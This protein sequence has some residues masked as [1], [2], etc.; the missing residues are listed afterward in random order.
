MLLTHC[1]QL[2][3]VW[4]PVEKKYEMAKEGD[5]NVS[6]KGICWVYQD[7]MVKSA[8]LPYSVVKWVRALQDDPD[9]EFD[10]PFPHI[11]TVNA[12][13]AG[14]KEVDYSTNVSPKKVYIPQNILDELSKKKS[15]EEIVQSIKDKYSV[16]EPKSIEYPQSDISPDDIPF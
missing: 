9:W 7:G 15:P 14:T 3:Q 12:K 13:N 2:A 10:F 11:L 5:K 1:A 4:N 6:I 16:P 8:R